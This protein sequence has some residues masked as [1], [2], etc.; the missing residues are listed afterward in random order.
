M[1]DAQ[2]VIG[3][4]RKHASDCK[5][6]GVLVRRFDVPVD[7]LG[8]YSTPNDARPQIVLQSESYAEL[9][10]P[11]L[12]SRAAILATSNEEAV[13]DGSVTLI[14][15]DAIERGGSY[16]LGICVIVGA[17][18]CLSDAY[19]QA[20][21][22]NLGNALSGCML[23]SPLEH[24]WCRIGESAVDK[25]FSLVDIAKAY[26]LRTK[27]AT[28]G[29]PVEVVMEVEAPHELG[30]FAG[31]LGAEEERYLDVLGQDMSA[32]GVDLNCVPGAHCGSCSDRKAC[33]E[34]RRIRSARNA[35]L[36]LQR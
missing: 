18:D 22:Q 20:H 35:A 27:R 34:V 17:S 26:L 8:D 6:R 14:G 33:E 3:E 36:E 19:L 31:I 13:S 32:R 30:E 24:P 21:R 15:R 5:A 2:E 10:G 28:G 11:K 12:G 7:Q 25:G 29:R 9:G 16:S 23:K 4:I 1:A